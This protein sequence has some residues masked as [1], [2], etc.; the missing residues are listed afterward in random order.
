MNSRLF[1]NF[2]NLVLASSACAMLA[3]CDTA[4]ST[5]G[6]GTTGACATV[7]GTWS[8]MQA[9][10]LK[11]CGSADVKNDTVEWTI[12]QSQC[13]VTVQYG[14]TTLNGTVGSG[15]M[16]L[17]GSGDEDEGTVSMSNQTLTV[18]ATA[19]SGTIHWTYAAQNST[20]N[21]TTTV[22]GVLTGKQPQ[23][24]SDSSTENDTLSGGSTGSPGSE[25][26]TDFEEELVGL[27]YR[28]H[29]YD[30]T[31][32]YYRFNAD[33]TACK[34]EED[35]GSSKRTHK[36]PYTSWRLEP[37]GQN[38]FSVVVTYESGSSSSVGIYDYVKDEFLNG[39]YSNLD[40]HKSSDGKV[41][42]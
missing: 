39:G 29:A 8:V 40:M 22:S 38:K 23:G 27:W 21:G 2:V 15:S 36:Q 6:P 25:P 34:W 17:T 16:T 32:Q 20:C 3:A 35:S 12:T 31:S 19:F 18:G 14:K 10:D 1:G 28:Y 11:E 37:E 4:P 42:E 5:G 26:L 30:G 7:A 9:A 33:R 13:L 41:C 24:G